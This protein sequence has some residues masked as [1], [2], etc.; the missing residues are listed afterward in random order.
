MREEKYN[1]LLWL[2]SFLIITMFWLFLGS[3]LINL[4]ANIIYNI[5]KKSIFFDTV[6]YNY[7]GINLPFLSILLGSYFC[8]KY[9]NKISIKE[10]INNSLKVDL[11]LIKNT[12]I[13][14][15]G[16]L[17]LI[18]VLGKI[19][20]IYEINYVNYNF[21]KRLIFIIIA[22]IF[23]PLQVFAEEI[24]YRSVLINTFI[25]NYSSLKNKNILY[26]I[27]LSIIIGIIF[28]FPHLFNPEVSSDFFSAT[29]YYFIFG[30]FATLSI[31]VTNGIEIAFST[32]LA[33]NIL[34][35]IFINYEESALTSLSFFIKTKETNFSKYYDIITLIILFII[36]SILNK[37]KIYEYI[38]H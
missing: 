14:C 37:K 32:H 19:L 30:S 24:L 16:Y 34:I 18:S 11:K 9:I 28:I 31:L 26:S 3:T 25:G 36:L 20:D 1:K 23:T 6:L 15:L 10:L 12:L 35:A 22:L 4:Y 17:L 5:D 27:G 2:A 21:S 29:L 33:N 13:I 38:R 8:F 7:I